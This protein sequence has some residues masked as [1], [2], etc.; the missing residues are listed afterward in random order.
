[1]KAKWIIQTNIFKEEAVDKM[2]DTFSR[3][4]IPFELVTIIP[5]SDEVPKVEPYDGPIVAYGTT[6]LLK[7]VKRTNWFPGMWFNEE[8]FKPSYWGGI[9]RDLYLNKDAEIMP[10]NE[11]AKNWKG[12]RQFIR[13]N[14]DFKLFSGD[15]FSKYEFE[16]WYENICNRI[17]DGTYVVL[18]KDTLVSVAPYNHILG[19]W[20]FA[21]VDNEIA[22]Y[23]RYR[24]LGELNISG[25]SLHIPIPAFD[26][27]QEIARD[28]WQLSP[29]Y[30][31]DIAY[32][33]NDFKVIEF[34]CFNASGFYD[35]DISSVVY[36]A[37]ELAEKQW[38]LRV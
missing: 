13:P 25:R 16:N 34:N 24:Y 5:F 11:V 19:E 27:A 1:M 7:N 29:A 36:K 38:K 21:I 8:R 22:G 33:G 20:R 32:T 37:T 4:H 26:V 23:S 18:K 31:V 12:E 2:V 17:D 3:L 35:C 9:I 15:V 28:G 14:S 6:T 10:L 30:V